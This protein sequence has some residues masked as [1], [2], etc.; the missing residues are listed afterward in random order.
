MAIVSSTPFSF[1]SAPIIVAPS[2]ANTLHTALPIPLPAPIYT[3]IFHG[4]NQLS[5]MTS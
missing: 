1:M 3:F 4:L 5:A 2:D